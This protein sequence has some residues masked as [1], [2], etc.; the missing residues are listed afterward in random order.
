MLH[1]STHHFIQMKLV[2]FGSTFFNIGISDRK[3]T[4]NYFNKKKQHLY[5][6]IKISI[7]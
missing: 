7:D 5:V 6:A 1:L 3:N 2:K 4:F